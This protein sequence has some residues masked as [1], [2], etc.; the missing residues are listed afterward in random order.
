MLFRSVLS[1]TPWTW[2]ASLRICCF[3]N[4]LPEVTRS[5]CSTTLV[6][7]EHSHSTN[8]HS[9][10]PSSNCTPVSPVN[11]SSERHPKPRPRMLHCH[12]IDGPLV[13][14]L[15]HVLKKRCQNRMIRRTVQGLNTASCSNSQDMLR[16]PNN[17]LHG[18]VEG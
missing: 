11:Y 16:N 18:S 14:V 3:V 9:T 7:L 10:S 2:C 1:E 17:G 5:K 12:C 4:T 6:N 15:F 13:D 8:L